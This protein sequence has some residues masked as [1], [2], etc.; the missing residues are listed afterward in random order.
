MSGAT[1]KQQD[2][3]DFFAEAISAKVMAKALNTVAAKLGEWGLI[4]SSGLG[5]LTN[6]A[7]R[8]NRFKD[9]TNWS[10]EI[11][12]SNPISFTETTDK[13]GASIFPRIVCEGI[14]VSYQHPAYPPFTAFDIAIEIVN[15]DQAPVARWHVD[16]AN[17]KDDGMQSGPLTHI[18]FGGH[19]QGHRDKDHPLKVPRWCHPPMDLILLCE[20]T[21]A[22]FYTDEWIELREDPSWCQAVH[23]GQKLC[24]TAYLNKISS[25]FTISSKTLLHSMWASEWKSNT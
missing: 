17:E 19:F 18:Q 7:S 21:A 1:H 24:Y 3:H 12:R 11:D 2:N 20:V 8:L 22:N 15:Q 14:S 10:L 25:S 13:N 5:A 4:T 9:D 16:L 6:E 23:I